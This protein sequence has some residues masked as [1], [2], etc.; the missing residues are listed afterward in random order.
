MHRSSRIPCA[1]ATVLLLY[2]GTILLIAQ[3]A[4]TAAWAQKAR[5]AIVLRDGTTHEGQYRGYDREKMEL[6]FSLKKGK[7]KFHLDRIQAITRVGAPVQEQA[8]P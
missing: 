4:S 6:E 3:C 5:Y 2:A 7:G 1:T 8:A